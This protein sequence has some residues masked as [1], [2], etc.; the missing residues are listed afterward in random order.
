MQRLGLGNTYIVAP[1]K[2]S[3]NATPA[4]VRA[5]TTSADQTR[6]QPDIS[7]QMTVDNLGRLLGSIYQCAIQ[8]SGPLLTAIPGAFD[9]RECRQMLKVMSDNNLGQPLLMSAGVPQNTRV[10]HKHGWIADT[11]GNAGIVFTPGGDYVFVV[12]LHN[13]IWL[14]FSE[15]FPLIT[16]MS[17]TIYNYYN[18]TTLM[19]T[20]RDPYIVEVQDCKIAGTPIV[21]AL[22]SYEG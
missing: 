22:M 19:Q 13:P 12:A 10:A 21:D 6:T 14:D 17:R 4:P 15:S 5:P 9:N 20:A 1:F 16:E 3:D 2:T 8:N 11:H 18:P 7:N